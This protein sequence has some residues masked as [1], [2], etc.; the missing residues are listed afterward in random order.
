M[1]VEARHI[2]VATIEQAE[3]LIKQINEGAD[4]SD[5]AQQHS[6]CPSGKNGGMLG[7]FSRGQMVK[8]FEDASFNLPIGTISE[9]VKTSFGFHIIKRTA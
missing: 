2:L 8:P 4:F 3:N 9:P 7:K 5:L 6:E 1:Q